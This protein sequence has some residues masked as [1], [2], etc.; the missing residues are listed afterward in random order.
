MGRIPLCNPRGPE[1]SGCFD[2]LFS[3]L[4]LAGGRRMA[5]GAKSK[6]NPSHNTQALSQTEVVANKTEDVEDLNQC[7]EKKDVIVL[8]AVSA[9]KT[10]I[11]PGVHLNCPVGPLEKL[12]AAIDAMGSF[13]LLTSRGASQEANPPG[14]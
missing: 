4:A 2:G 3:V 11:F 10:S 8:P 9:S 13:P 1:G 7:H 12:P 5:A 6:A 14:R